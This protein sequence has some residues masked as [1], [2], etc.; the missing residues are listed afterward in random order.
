ML[1]LTAHSHFPT[2]QYSV[3]CGPDFVSLPQPISEKRFSA[4]CFAWKSLQLLSCARASCVFWHPA[5]PHLLS[6][7]FHTPTTWWTKMTKSVKDSHFSLPRETNTGFPPFK[8]PGNNTHPGIWQRS[9]TSWGQTFASR[10]W[11]QSRNVSPNAYAKPGSE[12]ERM[13][14][15]DADVSKRRVGLWRS[16][17]VW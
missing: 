6:K 4:I 11:R 3:A 15:E 10:H 12:P 14:E 2:C 7:Q 13:M 1:Y 9:P 8:L 16:D 5:K 17:W